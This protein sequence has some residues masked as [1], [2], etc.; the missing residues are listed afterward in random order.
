MYLCKHSKQVRVW[1]PRNWQG[2][3]VYRIFP[4][5]ACSSLG[6]RQ[7]SATGQNAFRVLMPLPQLQGVPF[8]SSRGTLYYPPHFACL[9][10]DKHPPV[11]Y[12]MVCSKAPWLPQRE[13]QAFRIC[14]RDNKHTKTTWCNTSGKFSNTE[15]H[16]WNFKRILRFLI[17][18][19]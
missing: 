14:L 1:L 5:L 3:C 10:K 19:S 13:V 8:G 7:H 9:V 16:T 4:V 2:M 12:N 11:L 6:L 17:N 18:E 15:L